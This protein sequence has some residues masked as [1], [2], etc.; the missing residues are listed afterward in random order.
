MQMHLPSNLPPHL[1]AKSVCL[2]VTLR[3]G[4][5]PAQKKALHA[6]MGLALSANHLVCEF[7]MKDEAASIRCK[8]GAISPCE[9]IQVAEW[10]T[11]QGEVAK[12]FIAHGKT[13]APRMLEISFL[14]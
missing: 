12:V 2:D 8:N 13:P 4:I 11:Q 7:N 10:L 6:S 14:T 5:T 9:R 1:F 3:R